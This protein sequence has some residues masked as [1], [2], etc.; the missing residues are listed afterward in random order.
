MV[1][2]KLVTIVKAK[3]DVYNGLQLFPTL[4]KSQ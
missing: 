1:I 3:N 4:E 2:L